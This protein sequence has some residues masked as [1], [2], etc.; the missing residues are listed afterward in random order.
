MTKEERLLHRLKRQEKMALDAQEML[1]EA[2]RGFLSA[3]GWEPFSYS[4]SLQGW[5]DPVSK[6]HGPL[7]WAVRTAVAR[8]NELQQAQQK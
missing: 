7:S 5:V 3:L 1:E 8:I 4:E 6:R 2:Q